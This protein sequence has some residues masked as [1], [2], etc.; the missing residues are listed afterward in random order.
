MVAASTLKAK[1]LGLLVD[2]TEDQVERE[3]LAIEKQQGKELK[4]AGDLIAE[5]AESLGLPP[6]ATP[7][8]IVGALA[9]RPVATPEAFRLLHHAAISEDGRAH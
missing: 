9:E 3:R 1:L 8:Q 6:T 7:A 4:R 2:R 5:A